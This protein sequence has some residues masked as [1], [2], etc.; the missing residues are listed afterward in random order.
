MKNWGARTLENILLFSPQNQKV[1]LPWH[2]AI[3]R[4][5][6]ALPWKASMACAAFPDPKPEGHLCS[7][8]G[9]G[10]CRGPAEGKWKNHRPRGW[11][12]Q[13]PVRSRLLSSPWLSLSYRMS[14]AIDWEAR[15]SLG[16]VWSIQASLGTRDRRFQALPGFTLVTQSPLALG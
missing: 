4:G 2:L 12:G 6:P 16:T 11:E 13:S 1:I 9:G 7:H 15:R 3:L 5:F 14:T 10:Q 8:E